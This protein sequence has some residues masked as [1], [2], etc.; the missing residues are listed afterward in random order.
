ME[1]L[2]VGVTIPTF[3][4]EIEGIE[5]DADLHAE[6]CGVY[7][8]PEM[9]SEYEDEA[10]TYESAFAISEDGYLYEWDDKHAI[11]P[12]GQWH[13]YPIVRLEGYEAEIMC[14]DFML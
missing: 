2:P 11:S 5:L 13:K 3:S 12:D 9:E 14:M 7:Y 10:G 4:D 8:A 6:V 1:L